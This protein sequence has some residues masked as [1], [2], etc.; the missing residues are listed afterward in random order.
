[1]KES[2]KEELTTALKNIQSEIEKNGLST[3]P[4]EGT[5]MTEAK[6]SMD[7]VFF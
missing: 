2:E 3:I 1:M 6:K 4:S 5:T 7:S